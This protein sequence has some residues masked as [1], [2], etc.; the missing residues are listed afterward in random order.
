MPTLAGDLV[1]RT[2]D[3]TS[4]A[5]L[6][7]FR[8][9][10]GTIFPKAEKEVDDIIANACNLNVPER[11]NMIVRV[12][13]EVPPSAIVGVSGLEQGG[14]AFPHPKFTPHAYKDAAYVAVI[15]LS[16]HYRDD[17]D[18][19]RTREGGRLGDVVLHD[20]LL[21]VK[22]TWRGGMPWVLA[23]VDPDNESSRDLFERHDFRLFLE[24][25][26]DSL[27]RRPKNLK[28]PARPPSR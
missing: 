5:D 2:E 9:G 4:C 10:T 22:K 20:L 11:K 7:S 12:T 13:R 21:H 27:F 18:P 24:S 1:S 23:L 3:A 17:Q 8:C 16:E 25:T 26:P 6:K 19:F 15:G 28:V 14:I